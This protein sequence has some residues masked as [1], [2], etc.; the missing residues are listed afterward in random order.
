MNKGA[1]V[2]YDLATTDPDA[3]GRFYHEVVGWSVSRSP[4]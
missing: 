3:A 2:W 1:F 4:R